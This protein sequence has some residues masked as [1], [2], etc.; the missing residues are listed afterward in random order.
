MQ[1]SDPTEK[2]K[3]LKTQNSQ[4]TKKKKNHVTSIEM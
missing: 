4:Q 3:I 2:C 1:T